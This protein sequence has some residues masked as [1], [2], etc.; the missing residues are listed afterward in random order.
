V[1]IWGHMDPQSLIRRGEPNRACPTC[2]NPCRATKR[3]GR[4]RL[5]L[6]RKADGGSDDHRQA[7][8]QRH[9][10]AQRRRG[11][12]DDRAGDRCDGA[13]CQD[14]PPANATGRPRRRRNHARRGDQDQAA[15]ADGCREPAEYDDSAHRSPPRPGRREELSQISSST[16]PVEPSADGIS[17]VSGRSWIAAPSI[18]N[19]TIEPSIGPLAAVDSSSGSSPPP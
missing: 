2:P 18:R 15:G 6:G 13:R 7:A 19:S 11:L 14:P 17:S 3:P 16:S 9:H 8:E 1:W 10:A 12:G 4:N 5:L